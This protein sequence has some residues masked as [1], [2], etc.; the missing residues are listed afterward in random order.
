[1]TLYTANANFSVMN[2]DYSIKRLTYDLTYNYA[3]R[4]RLPFYVLD[5]DCDSSGI[6][7]KLNV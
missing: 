2:T 7:L 3:L 6:D 4:V 1:M 5:H